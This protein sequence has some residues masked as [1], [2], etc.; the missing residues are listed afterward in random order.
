MKKQTLATAPLPPPPSASHIG[1]NILGCAVF[2]YFAF[3]RQQGG[4]V[5]PPQELLLLLLAALLPMVAVDVWRQWHSGAYRILHP[6]HLRRL[7]IK[8]LGLYATYG[9]ILLAYWALPEYKTT[10][11]QRVIELIHSALPWLAGAAI[12]YFAWMDSRMESPEDGNYHFG[13]LT[14][15]QWKKA[16][17]RMA[18][19]HLKSWAVKGF[20]LPLMATFLLQNI[21]G[22]PQFDYSFPYFMSFYHAAYHFLFSL[23]LLF[24]CTGYLM[25]LRLLNTQIYSAEPTVLGWLACLMC[26]QP[27]WA[28]AFYPAYFAYDDGYFWN[29]WVAG[30]PLLQMIWGSAILLC[31]FIY[32]W[33]TV[34]FGYR[35][36]NLTYRGLI[37]NGPYRFTKHP[38]YVF[39][40][41][42][43]WLVSVPF[44]VTESLEKS[45]QQCLLLAGVCAIYFLRARTEENH[46]SNYP[47][48]VAY[49][50]WM[51]R[52]SMFRL[53]G[54]IVPYFAY[55]R[56]R[57]ARSGSRVYAPYAGREVVER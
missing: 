51:N 42:S 10:F 12:P 37:A 53:L 54:Q 15:G 43:W 52:H 35:F 3:T 45:L 27:I 56:E 26:Y 46:L 16:D 32:A 2:F 39:K 47:E 49:A 20:F 21:E 28:A 9:L 19:E 8:L 38:A 25:T 6:F 22:I 18:G 41:L 17:K 31:L 36:S 44:I 5:M 55:S 57:A 48:Y 40:C 23:D 13:L 4:R 11:Y 14:S 24:A 50:E 33:A 30:E 34:A 1:A 29:H 7:L